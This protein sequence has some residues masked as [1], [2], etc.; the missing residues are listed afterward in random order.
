[1][2][3]EIKTIDGNVVY[4]ISDLYLTEYFFFF[5]EKFRDKR[6][7]LFETIIEL[8]Y[9]DCSLEYYFNDDEKEMKIDELLSWFNSHKTNLEFCS[10]LKFK[11]QIDNCYLSMNDGPIWL[12]FANKEKTGENMFHFFCNLVL[13]PLGLELSQQEIDS[14]IQNNYLE[15]PYYC[16]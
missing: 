15:L 7:H 5:L 1:M 14:M 11:I 4:E 8:H 9:L 3:T 10:F 12:E 2:I 13:S 16:S 6:I